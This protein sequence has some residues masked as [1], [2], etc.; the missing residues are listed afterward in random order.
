MVSVLEDWLCIGRQY[1]L[2]VQERRNFKHIYTLLAKNVVKSCA[3]RGCNHAT[4]DHVF[5]TSR[6][7]SK[8]TSL[9]SSAHLGHPSPPEILAAARPLPPSRGRVLVGAGPAAV[10]GAQL[11]PGHLAPAAVGAAKVQLHHGKL[12]PEIQY[13]YSA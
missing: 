6:V 7:H 9:P 8:R 1:L 4:L 12:P 13:M 3:S 5:L 2:T 10:D 11:E